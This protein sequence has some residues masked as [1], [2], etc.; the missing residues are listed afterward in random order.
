MGTRFAVLSSIVVLT[1]AVGAPAAA[2]ERVPIKGAFATYADFVPPPEPAPFVCPVP[3]DGTLLGW[4]RV[5]GT[6]KVSHLGLT[7]FDNLQCIWV[8]STGQQGLYGEVDFVAANGDALAVSYDG[9]VIPTGPTTIEFDGAMTFIGGTGRFA[10]AAGE[11]PYRGA[12]SF[13]TKRGSIDLAGRMSRVG[14]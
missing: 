12:Y 14:S 13:A 10:G 3:A 7:T 5:R 6:G 8:D 9:V 4:V 1:F 11:A 2:A